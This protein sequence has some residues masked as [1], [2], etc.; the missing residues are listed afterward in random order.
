MSKGTNATKGNEKWLNN[1]YS[2][3]MEIVKKGNSL[4]FSSVVLVLLYIFNIN[5]M[6]N[7]RNVLRIAGSVHTWTWVVVWWCGRGRRWSVWGRTPRQAARYCAQEVHQTP[8]AQAEKTHMARLGMKVQNSTD[9]V[10]GLLLTA[11]QM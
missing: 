2:K 8:P 9:K 5:V 4:Y 1:L 6:C 11:L 10:V 7:K 3:A